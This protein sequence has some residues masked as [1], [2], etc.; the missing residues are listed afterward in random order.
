M[1]KITVSA[2]GLSCLLSLAGCASMLG[3]FNEVLVGVNKGD[4]NKVREA[5]RAGD[6]YEDGTKEI[7]GS[8]I[9]GERPLHLAIQKGN[10]E[11]TEILLQE[12]ADPDLPSDI[13]R[14]P[15]VCKS[16]GILKTTPGLP[17]MHYAITEGRP[18]FAEALLFAGADP[19]LKTAKGKTAHDLALGKAGFELLV[20]YIESPAHLAARTG[21]VGSLSAAARKGTDL[22]SVMSHTGTTPL[23]EALAARKFYVVDFLFENGG[24]M[25]E[26]ISSTAATDAVSEYLD[27]YNGTANA[28]KLRNMTAR[29]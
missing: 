13:P 12:G 8:N 24:G 3:D 27:E 28:E 15:S 19:A 6:T 21:D 5:A 2:F 1:K 4:A 29:R 14:E 10:L 23:E 20:A 16:F 9:C 11:I 25:Q 17:P 26:T 7:N 18:A 22:N